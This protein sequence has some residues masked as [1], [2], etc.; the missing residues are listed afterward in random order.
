[1]KTH[2]VG[3]FILPRKAIFIHRL[4]D[5]EI[6]HNAPAVGRIMN[7]GQIVNWRRIQNGQIFF[8]KP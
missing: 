6:I 2:V 3:N 1:M 8:Q 5:F 7:I 4:K